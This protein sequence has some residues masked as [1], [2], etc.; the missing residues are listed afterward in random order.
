[1][2]GWRA[3]F[4][5]VGLAVLAAA[6]AGLGW[7]AMG[8]EARQALGPAEIGRGPY[9]L[10][11][12]TGAP[13]TQDSLRGA[14]SLVFVGFTHCPDVCPTTLGDIA[15]WQDMLGPQRAADLRVYFITVDPARDTLPVL[16]AYISWLPGAVGVTGSQAEID[17][18]LAAFRAFA[19][20]VAM[21]DGDY[22]MEHTASVMVFDAEGRLSGT[23]PYQSPP[24]LAV[25]RITAALEG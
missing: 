16:Q 4:A 25:A 14:P 11:S 21:A 10:Q 19:R 2:T 7:W 13:F 9:R 8:P 24:D 20:R 6:L 1:M 22:T 18:A 15:L 17:A 12:T 23:I 5:I 3:W